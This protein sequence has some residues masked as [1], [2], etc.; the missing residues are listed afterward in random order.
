MSSSSGNPSPAASSPAS[1]RAVLD[2]FEGPLAQIRFPGVDR[3]S[4]A[5]AEGEVEARRAELQRALEAVACA[6]ELLEEAQS[7]LFDQV[8]RAHAY[9][10]V[11]AEGD[12]ALLESLRKIELEPHAAAPK[13]PRGRPP[14]QRNAKRQTSLT[15]ADDAA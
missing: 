7:A 8:R 3:E 4:L 15:V 9:A 6:R 2:L 14:K 11:F 13:K 1:V 12:D 5:E 10:T